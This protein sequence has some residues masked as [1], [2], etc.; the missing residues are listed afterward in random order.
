MVRNA[1]ARAD[2]LHLRATT[3]GNFDAGVPDGEPLHRTGFGDGEAVGDDMRQFVVDV[4]ENIASP[5]GQLFRSTSDTDM[6][7]LSTPEPGSS[8]SE[9]SDSQAGSTCGESSAMEHDVGSSDDGD[10]PDANKTR[11]VTMTGMGLMI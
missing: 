5:Q 3:P 1:F 7:S 11:P 9:S 4:G 6:H 10:L 2:N 8:M